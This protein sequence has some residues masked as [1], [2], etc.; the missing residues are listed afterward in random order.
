MK[1]DTVRLHSEL[2]SYYLQV[3]FCVKAR[4][5]QGSW[6]ELLN[7]QVRATPLDFTDVH[8]AQNISEYT[9]FESFLITHNAL[10]KVFLKMLHCIRVYL[11]D[12]GRLPVNHSKSIQKLSVSEHKDKTRGKG[13]HWLCLTQLSAG[14][15]LFTISSRA[16][17][18]RMKYEDNVK[19]QKPAVPKMA[20]CMSVLFNVFN[21][22]RLTG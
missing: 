11:N 8:C 2:A 10:L 21:T 9:A 5:L 19:V 13:H 20:T 14:R 15:A 22:H 7:L 1:A 3:Y 18:L 17:P 16:A 4:S 6:S 12:N